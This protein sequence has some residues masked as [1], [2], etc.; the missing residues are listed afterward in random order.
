MRVGLHMFG[1][2]KLL[3]MEISRCLKQ[4]EKRFSKICKSKKVSRL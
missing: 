4:F 3:Y 2:V 1:T